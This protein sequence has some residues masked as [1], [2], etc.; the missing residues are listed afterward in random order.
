MVATQIL[1]FLATDDAVARQSLCGPEWHEIALG[2]GQVLPLSAADFDRLLEAGLIA[3]R[4][5]GSFVITAAG[6]RWLKANAA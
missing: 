5:E 3:A 4:E 2:D 1:G 6:R